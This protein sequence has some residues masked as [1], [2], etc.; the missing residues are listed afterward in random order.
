M[1]LLKRRFFR[2][3]GTEP[4]DP[5]LSELGEDANEVVESY[6]TEG[7]REAQLWMLA[8]GYDGWRKRSSALAWSGSD[9]ADGGTYSDLP[10]DFLRAYGDGRESALRQANGDTWG[11]QITPRDDIRVGNGYY[12]RGSQV[13]LTR[14]AQPA[15]T[16]YLEYHYKHPDF[17]GLADGDI[18][19]P[20]D[21]RSLI[22]TYGAERA[23]EE[24]WLPGGPELQAKVERALLKAQRLALQVARQ[25]K[26]PRQFRKAV[27]YGNH[28]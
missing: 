2:L 28:W 9:D 8:Q 5:M 6:L 11:R 17:T 12:F 15:T 22:P 24:N 13:W 16:L 25:S 7:T 20:V 10:S 3:L 21:A 4:D 27:R 1:G 14:R 26:Q 18:D 19:F 23:M